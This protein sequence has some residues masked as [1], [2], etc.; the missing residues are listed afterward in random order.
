MTPARR[1][2]PVT[3]RRAAR[4][5]IVVVGSVN[6]DMVSRVDALPAPGQTVLGDDVRLFDG[7]K[8]ANQAVGVARLGY[9]VILIARVGG[10]PAGVRLTTAL[11]SRGVDMR[12]TM[13]TR[14]VPS[15]MALI[16][17][18]RRGQNSIVVSPGANARLSPAD[19]DRRR[20]I[21]RSAGMVLVQ[22]EIPLE[23]V[24]RVVA[25]AD[26]AG[27]PVMLDP[28]PARE[29]PPRLMRR[30]AWLTPNETE[31]V[32]LCDGDGARLRPATWQRARDLAGA[33]RGRGA[34]NVVVTLGR[35][36]CCVAEASGSLRGHRAFR[37]TAVDT[38]AAGDAF[39]AGLAVA[40]LR[41]RSV[42]DAIRYASAAA[43]IAVTR[44]GAQPS[45]PNDRSVAR[46][47]ADVSKR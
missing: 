8:G 15:G 38:T 9:P 19:I 35:R 23:T 34:R 6:L 16:T 43:A 13:V 31:A 7:G 10:D 21:L 5:P 41:G 33:L 14:G 30:I 45:M 20:G 27:V 46:F 12:A 25:L 22:L 36:G 2:A 42:P 11:A 17:T 18:D 32:R 26:E 47:M 3:P 4:R 29:F 44:R 28:A 24:V 40:L 37:V 39:N 1:G